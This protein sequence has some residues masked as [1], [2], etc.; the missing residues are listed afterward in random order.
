MIVEGSVRLP[1][2]Y[3]AGRTASAFLTA[4]RDEGI[5]LGA[6]CSACGQVAC[7]ARSL[8]PHCGERAEE[9]V[10]VGPEGTLVSWTEAPG[11]GAYGLVKL[12]GADT[13]LVHRLLGPVDVRRVG[14]RVRVRVAPERTAS[15]LDIEGFEVAA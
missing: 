12:D 1:F 10:E 6:R 14:A 13:A 7:P 2:R 9:L 5:V 8:C 15:I 3:A 4:L 11:R